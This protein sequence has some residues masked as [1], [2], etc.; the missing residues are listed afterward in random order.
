MVEEHRRVPDLLELHKRRA[1]RRIGGYTETE[2]W[3]TC[4]DW[5]GPSREVPKDLSEPVTS[6]FN[7]HLSQTFPRFNHAGSANPYNRSAYGSF[8]RKTSWRGCR[9]RRE[10][11]QEEGDPTHGGRGASDRPGRTGRLAGGVIPGPLAS[12]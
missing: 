10:G 11:S 2:S 9:R 7:E 4:V 1:S 6:V 3:A 5:C 12:V 8:P